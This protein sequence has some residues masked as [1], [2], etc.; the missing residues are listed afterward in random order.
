MADLTGASFYLSLVTA[1]LAGSLHCVGMCGPILAGFAQVFRG[2]G[3]EVE[4]RF[5]TGGLW[6]DFAAYHLGRIWTYALLGL[7]AG[8]AGTGMRHGSVELGWQRP[9]ALVFCL[10]VILSGVLLLGIVPGLK[11]DALIDG[12]A[13]QRLGRWPPFRSLLRGSGFPARLLLGAV[14][15]LLPCG[16]VYAMLVLAAALPTPLHAAAAMATFGIGT[17][18]ALSAVLLAGRLIPPWVRAHGTRIAAVLLILTGVWM[19]ARTLVASSH[20]HPI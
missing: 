15:G 9:V 16:L 7:V 4:R 19:T 6:L 18:P 17:I 3:V 14:M 12:C 20:V 10:L 1:G 5:S 8:L 11:P 13:L 2:P